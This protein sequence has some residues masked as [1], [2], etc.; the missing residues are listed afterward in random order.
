[1]RIMRFRNI[2][3]L[4]SFFLVF[5]VCCKS[6]VKDELKE[7]AIP[8]KI[9]SVYEKEVTIPIHTSGM[10]SP[11]FNMKLSFK[12]GGIIEKIYVDEG[13]S[14]KKGCMLARLDLSEIN[15]IFKKAE[16]GY[17]KS[18]RDLKRIKNLYNDRAATLEQLQN[19]KTAFKVAESSLN[20]ARFNL[21]HS[22]IVAP[23]NG[24]ILRQLVE[25]NEMI[26]A[27]MPVFLFGST[28]EQWVIKAGVS[29]KDIIRIK[30]DDP[31][32]IK[33][34]AYPNKLF[35]AK[36]SEVSEALDQI[37]G[38]YEIELEIADNGLKLVS[39]FYAK[40]D[41]YPSEKNVYKLI[42]F[43]ALI[44]GEGNNGFVFTIKDKRAEKV[45]IKIE[46]L[47]KDKIAVQAGLEHVT[48]VVISGAPYLIDGCLVR[49]IE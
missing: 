32:D 27:G 24:K 44:E 47:F 46:H 12:T 4:I 33:F 29:E 28:E 17:L 18:E 45:K 2:I 15:A 16:N 19:V 34:D 40:V 7:N 25:I 11:K 41:I 5:Y 38:T 30:K 8:V 13:Q 35:S 3:F 31:A 14:V 22:R 6:K 20:I 39:G 21:K 43:D 9:A 42:P 48:D 10:L 23:S 36:V 37:S 49:I 26:G 1:M